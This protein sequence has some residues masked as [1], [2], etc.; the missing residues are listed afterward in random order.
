VTICRTCEVQIRQERKESFQFSN[1]I[2]LFIQLGWLSCIQKPPLASPLFSS[3]FSHWG[4]NLTQN[5]RD[6]NFSSGSRI[7]DWTD[8]WSKF[9]SPVNTKETERDKGRV[10]SAWLQQSS[11]QCEKGRLTQM[12]SLSAWKQQRAELDRQP[13]KTCLVGNSLCPRG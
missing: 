10:D 9:C 4:I 13:G 3:V 5:S 7:Y 1:N 11:G 8:F 2:I 6:V 12:P